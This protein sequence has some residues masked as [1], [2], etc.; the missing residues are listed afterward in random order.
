MYLQELYIY[1]YIY[2]YDI[3]GY[4]CALQ[5]KTL[6]CALVTYIRTPLNQRRVRGIWFFY[7][8]IKTF[9]T[10]T[11]THYVGITLVRRFVKAI[12][13]QQ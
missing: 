12:Y 11:W 2:I 5:R 13:L 7:I 9:C 4:G 6:Y 1:I 8:A 3:A 10:L